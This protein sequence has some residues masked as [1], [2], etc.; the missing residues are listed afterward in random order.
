VVL[1]RNGNLAEA[2]RRFLQALFLN[3]DNVAATMNA[4]CCSNLLAGT[5]PGLKDLNRVADGFRSIQ[6]LAQVMSQCGS[7]D[8]PSICLILGNVCAANGWPRQACLEFD[9]ANKLA[10]ESMMPDFALAQIYSRFRFD[11]ETLASVNRLRTKMNSTN[12]SLQLE[13]TL[14]LLEARAWYFKTNPAAANEVLETFRQKHPDNAPLVDTIFKAY[15]AFGEMSN[16]LQVVEERLV[17]NPDDIATLNNRAA[18]L[19]QMG[20]PAEAVSIFNHALTLTNAP[21]I[22]LNRAFAYLQLKDF[23]AAKKDYTELENNP[24]VDAFNVHYGLA[25]VAT[26]QHDTNAAISNF[27]FCLSNAPPGS[28]KWK[29]VRDEFETFKK[30]AA[31]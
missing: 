9:R 15:L 16:A 26:I 29:T 8:N 17:K 7:F 27:E 19:I 28:L 1:Q 12:T 2:G 4:A 5:Y 6:Q 21:Y 14:S 31:R 3:K 30:P 22:R 10:P 24:A 13:L 18:V 23:A 25:R 11:D 20:R